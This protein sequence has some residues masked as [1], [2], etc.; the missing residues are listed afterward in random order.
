[1]VRK[2]FRTLELPPTGHWWNWASRRIGLSLHRPLYEREAIMTR[3]T[4]WVAMMSILI[5]MGGPRWLAAGAP[6]AAPGRSGSTGD[7]P[8]GTIAFASLAP[9]GWD[10]YL[11]EVA[12]RRTRRLTDHPALDGNAVF[13]A[14]G[15]TLAFVST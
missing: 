2:S 1:M 12:S 4:H 5:G 14:D 7:R 3:R 15:R 11:V 6:P 8:A 13:A 9:R 10:V